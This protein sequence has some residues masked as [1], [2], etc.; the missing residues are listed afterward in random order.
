M[1]DSVDLQLK[2]WVQAQ[3]GGVTV[4]FSPP[5]AIGDAGDGRVHLYLLQ[6][7]PGLTRALSPANGAETELVLRYL[8]TVDA[9][10]IQT[11]HG[12]LGALAFAALDSPD[13]DIEHEPPGPDL[14]A[15]LGALPQPCVLLRVPLR[16]QRP[17]PDTPRVRAPLAVERAALAGLSGQVLGPD[18]VPLAGAHVEIPGLRLHQTTDARGRFH[19]KTIPDSRQQTLRIRAKGRETQVAVEPAQSEQPV[20]IRLNPTEGEG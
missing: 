13:F 17:Q 8:L 4:D 16:R 9:G 3:V 12:I 2:D 5:A 18:D 7:A 19:F 20:I 6:I 15:A 14:W 10:D 11:A 1:I